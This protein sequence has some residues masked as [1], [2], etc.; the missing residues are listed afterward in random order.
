MADFRVDV[1]H[2]VEPDETHVVVVEVA[3]PDDCASS[4]AACNHTVNVQA[5]IKGQID[6]TGNARITVS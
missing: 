3:I 4:S 1:G 5:D 6:P 2:T